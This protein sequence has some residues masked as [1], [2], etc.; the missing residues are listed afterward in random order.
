MGRAHE[1]TD[2]DGNCNVTYYIVDYNY[3]Y[4]VVKVQMSRCFRSRLTNFEVTVLCTVGLL[5]RRPFNPISQ[6]V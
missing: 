6:S 2:H 5:G 4:C 3:L 1:R